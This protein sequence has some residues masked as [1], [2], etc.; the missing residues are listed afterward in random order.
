MKTVRYIVWKLIIV[1]FVVTCFALCNSYLSTRGTNKQ[2]YSHITEGHDA[3]A[4]GS[5][6]P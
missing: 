3:T 5:M 6:R 2:T 4:F 1:L